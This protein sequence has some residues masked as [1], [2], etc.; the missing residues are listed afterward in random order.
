[1]GR[2]RSAIALLL[3]LFFVMLISI[4]IGFSLQNLNKAKQSVSK[5]K[6]LLQVDVLVDDILEL[7]K[8]SSEIDTVVKSQ[9]GNALF[10]LISSM[11]N[12]P[13]SLEGYE[14]VLSV[15]SARKYFNINALKKDKKNFD[16]ERINRI[17]NFFSTHGI[18]EELVLMFMDSMSGYKADRSYFT[19]LFE[20]NK[21]LFRDYIASYEHLE[22][23]LLFYD[24]KYHDNVFSKLEFDKIF[25]YD[26]NIA[27][28]VDL[29]F[30]TEQTWE[31][32]TG[33]SQE[34]AKVFV[35]NEGSYKKVEDIPLSPTM[36]ER[37]KKFNISFFEPVVMIIIT[38]RDHYSSGSVAFEYNLRTKK[39]S[40]FVYKI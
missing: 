14:V 37:L 3:T 35:K 39:A 17:K 6:L 5:E 21:E 20:K 23:I 18:N 19:D 33:C 25:S 36:K 15:E 32:L 13:L 22:K 31:F 24:K 10:A 4:V 28:K 30:A 27:T 8:T 40:R 9:D 29:N 38:I 34:E 26:P 11:Q 12:I 2:S 7:L 16:R 1:M